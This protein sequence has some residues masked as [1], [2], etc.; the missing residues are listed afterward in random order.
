MKRI[1]CG[2]SSKREIV[3]NIDFVVSDVANPIAAGSIVSEDALDQY[4]YGRL[5]SHFGDFITDVLGLL[6]DYNC[7]IVGSGWS[8]RNKKR[9]MSYYIHFYPVTRDRDLLVKFLINMRLSD[10][11]ER[12]YAERSKGFHDRFADKWKRSKAEIQSHLSYNIV[13][14]GV[15]FNSYIEALEYIEDLIREFRVDPRNEVEETSSDYE[16]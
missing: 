5:R 16:T 8:P 3:V 9:Q 1:V 15:E 12:N 7:A 6:H 4:P 11:S 14:D 13:I 2:L 10:H